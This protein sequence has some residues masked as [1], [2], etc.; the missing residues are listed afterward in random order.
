MKG[1]ERGFGDGTELV[2]ELPSCSLL[3]LEIS[4]I[5]FVVTCPLAIKFSSLL[6][7]ALPQ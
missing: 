7:F 3:E 5:I 4:S 1:S 6:G 2:I